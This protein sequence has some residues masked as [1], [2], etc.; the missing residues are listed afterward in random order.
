MKRSK[1]NKLLMTRQNI[2]AT[3]VALFLALACVGCDE[4]FFGERMRI[5]TEEAPPGGVGVPYRWEIHAEVKNEPFDDRYDYLFS[6]QEGAL[7]AGLAFS[8]AGDYALVSGTPL[9]PG[10]F[11][12]TVRVTSDTLRFEELREEDSTIVDTGDSRDFRILINP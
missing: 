8:D 11:P 12:I 5:T 10:T 2:P 4:E 6:L 3:L 1:K 9:E 7:P